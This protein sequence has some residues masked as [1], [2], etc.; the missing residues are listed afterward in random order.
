MESEKSVM[1][2][3]SVMVVAA[4]MLLVSCASGLKAEE[5]NLDFKLVNSTGHTIKEVYIAPSSTDEWGANIMKEAFKDGAT[6]DVTFHPK[7]T[8]AKWDIRIVW[9]DGDTPV[10]WTG[11]KLDEIEKLTLKYD[12]ETEKTTAIVE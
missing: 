11:C 12:S 7:A 2:M 5:L 1:R 4:A 6:L 8:A 3:N 9:A 10:I